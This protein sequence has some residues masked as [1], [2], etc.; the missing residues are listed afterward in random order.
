MVSIAERSLKKEFV[1]YLIPSV[2]AQWVFALYTMVDGMFVAR[3]VGEVALAAVN[4]AQ[5]FVSALFFISILMAAGSSTIISIQFGKENQREANCT[6]SQNLLTVV[7]LS[8]LVVVAGAVNLE[9]IV[10]FL[11][12]SEDTFQLVKVYIKT[13]VFFAP[14]FMLSYYFEI[15]IKADGEPRLATLLVFMGTIIN[16][17]LDYLFVF[18]IRWG[19]FGAAFATGISQLAVTIGFALYFFG[20]RARLRLCRFRFRTSLIGKTIQLGLPMGVSDLSS[21]IMVFFLNHAILAHLGDNAI[22]SYTIAAY[23]CTIVLMSTSGVAQGMQPLVSYN[24]GRGHIEVCKRLFGYGVIAALGIT[25]IIFVLFWGGA[26]CFVDIFVSSQQVEL[27]GYSVHVFRIITLSVLPIGFNIVTA[28]WL[29]AVT[30]E[31]WAL[32]ISV[33]RSILMLILVLY[34]FIF[35]WGGEAIWWAPV[36]SELLC[37]AISAGILVF[38]FKHPCDGR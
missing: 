9:K 27:R 33:M 19:V 15:L 26:G 31:K 32:L 37:C 10:F 11:G 34:T 35:I 24:Y 7:I 5:P 21:G 16:C 23:I 29:A 13:I 12:A 17:V 36:V 28:G 8:I 38:A 6:Y 14:C 20:R 3:G 30:K 4:L 25:L 22:V 1:R 2:A 18:V